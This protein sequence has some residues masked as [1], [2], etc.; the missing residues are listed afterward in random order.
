MGSR[1]SGRSTHTCLGSESDV[2]AG[3]L[4]VTASSAGSI[5][6]VGVVADDVDGVSA[7]V[8]GVPGPISSGSEGL[9][10]NSE[11]VA[12]SSARRVKPKEE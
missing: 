2:L 3:S 8:A 6:V 10:S 11:V 9:K 7:A 12:S 5:V 4:Y 1:S